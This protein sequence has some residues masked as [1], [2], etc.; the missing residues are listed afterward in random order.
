MHRVRRANKRV[1]LPYPSAT[2]SG[3]STPTSGTADSGRGDPVLAMRRA[4]QRGQPSRC[5]SRR[6]PCPRW[7]GHTREHAR[8]LL[9]VQRSTRLR[10]G[11]TKPARWETEGGLR[12]W[13]APRWES[14]ARDSFR[15]SERAGQ[16]SDATKIGS[17]WAVGPNSFEGFAI[18]P[19]MSHFV[20]RGASTSA[21][22]TADT[23]Q[24]Q[25]PTVSIPGFYDR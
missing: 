18:P 20:R 5:R 1:A 8:G 24:P 15:P 19:S 11:P 13:T 17:R 2:T 3:Q 9:D 23:P 25:R 12:Q 4:R 7:R 21:R 14:G 22:A 6:P 10:L 16:T